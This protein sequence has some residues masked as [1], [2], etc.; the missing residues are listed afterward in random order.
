MKIEGT[1]KLKLFKTHM[2][3]HKFHVVVDEFGINYDGILARDFFEDKQSINYCYQQIIMGDVVVKFDPKPDSASS[4]N[5]KLTLKARSESIV[6]MPTKSLGDGII[7]KS[8]NARRMLAESLTKAINWKFIASIVSSLE[9]D[10]I[11]DPPQFR[12]EA[13][14]DNEEAITL[15]HTAVQVEITGPLSILRE[16]LRTDHLNDEKRISHVKICDEYN[17]FFVYQGIR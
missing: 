11:L 16:Q 9:Q 7:I 4:K 17:D 13:V 14:E 15:I 10:I 2:K 8:N 3:T 12:L 1:I 5:C 6:K